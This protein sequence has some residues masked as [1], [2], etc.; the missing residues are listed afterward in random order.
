LRR[1]SRWKRLTARDRE[2]AERVERGLTNAQIA[3]KLGI[4]AW[5]IV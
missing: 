4:I 1:L 2:I 5:W 3:D